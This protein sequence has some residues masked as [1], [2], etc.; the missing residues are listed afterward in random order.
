MTAEPLTGDEIAALKKEFSVFKVKN[1][2][3]GVERNMVVGLLDKDKV[4]L[5]LGIMEEINYSSRVFVLWVPI[6]VKEDT[7]I[8]IIQFG[9]IKFSP[10]MKEAG[11]VEPG[12]F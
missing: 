9:S 4:C 10:E 1:I 7:K 8:K 5:G 11:F 2:V 12:Y 3:K 6:K